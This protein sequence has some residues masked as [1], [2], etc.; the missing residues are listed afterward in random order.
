M[1]P[2]WSFQGPAEHGRVTLSLHTPEPPRW[3]GAGGMR[4]ALLRITRPHNLAPAG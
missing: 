4:Q 2:L 3:A 1:T